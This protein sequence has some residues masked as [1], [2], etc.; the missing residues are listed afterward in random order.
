MTP[1]QD[2][3]QTVTKYTPI[4]KLMPLADNDNPILVIRK[5]NEVIEALNQVAGHNMAT[6]RSEPAGG[7]LEPS[8][9][10]P[11]DTGGCKPY[12]VDMPLSMHKYYD[13]SIGVHFNGS[14]EEAEAT[15]AALRAVLEYIQTPIQSDEPT[16]GRMQTK[17]FKDLTEARRT[18]QAGRDVQ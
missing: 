13:W 11:E 1:E 9:S 12:Q 8:R 18:V 16:F 10:L 15:A 14:R 6:E 4:E 3:E 5:L 17:I 7:D 2:K